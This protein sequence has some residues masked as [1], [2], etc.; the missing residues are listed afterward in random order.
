MTDEKI[1]GKALSDEELDDIGGGT[2]VD[3]DC[4]VP[5]GQFPNLGK[6]CSKGNSISGT[7]YKKVCPYCSI[8]SSLPEGTSLVITYIVECSRYGYGKRIK[9]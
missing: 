3:G 5:E 1:P 7:V 6:C 9:E 4:G 8:W 2:G